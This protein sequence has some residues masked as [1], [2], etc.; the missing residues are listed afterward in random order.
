MDV[1]VELF[2][3]RVR[4]KYSKALLPLDNFDGAGAVLKD[5]ATAA[6]APLVAGNYKGSVGKSLSCEMTTIEGVTREALFY[7]L[8]NKFKWRG[9]GLCKRSFAR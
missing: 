5:V 2:L 6:L 1:A 8:G 7:T 9:N 4:K 3:L